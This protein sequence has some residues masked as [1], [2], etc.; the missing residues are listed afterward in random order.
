MKKIALI[1]LLVM[2]VTPLASC[3]RE[4][5]IL[6]ESKTY[7][8]SSD[9][10]SLEISLISANLLIKHA[11]A[12]YV[13]SNLKHLDVSENNGILTIKD[14]SESNS[15]FDDAAFTLYIPSD[16]V[17]ENVDIS[18]GAAKLTAEALS[19]KSLELKLGAGDV[20]FKKLNVSSKTHIEGGAGQINILDGELTNLTLTMGYG[21]MN[22]TAS[23]LGDSDLELGV[24]QS[25]ITLLG[26]RENYY[27]KGTGLI[28]IDG[29]KVTGYCNIGS[30]KNKIEIFG[31]IGAVNIIFK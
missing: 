18:T 20:R 2:F 1:L 13:E 30:G 4:S 24:G 12:I 28:Y 31:G 29:E 19:A 14:T 8:V 16:M 27:I 7:S 25:N 6:D 17:F 10:H 22:L 3:K 11:D 15:K 5:A 9:I 21:S 26:K 23:L